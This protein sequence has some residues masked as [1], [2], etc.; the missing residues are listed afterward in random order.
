MTEN[1]KLI[2]QSVNK[3]LGTEYNLISFDSLSEDQLLQVLLDVFLKY[4]IISAKWDVTENDPDETNKTIMESLA[5]IQYSDEDID[6]ASLRRG[7]VR[8]DKKIIYPI[9]E[10]IFENEELITKLAYLA[11]FLMPLNLPPEAMSIPEVMS[12]NS[13]YEIVMDEFKEVHQIYELAVDDGKKTRELRSDSMAIEGEIDNVKKRIERLQA[14]LDKIPQHELLLESAKTLRIEKDK[15]KDLMTQLDEQKQ[16]LYRANVI[17]ERLQKEFQNIKSSTQGTTAKEMLDGIIEEK[18]VLEFMVK[19]KLPQELQ[20]RQSEVQ[21]LEDVINEPTIN[22]EYLQDLQH[23]IDDVNREIQRLVEAKMNDKGQQNDVLGLGPFRQQA[24][25]IAR[26]KDAAAEQLDQLTKELK[27]VEYQLKDKQQKLQETVGEVLLRGDDLKQF[28]NTLRA[29]SNVYKQQRSELAAIKA[30]AS[31]LQETLDNLRAQDPSLS[32]PDE[33]PSSLE[34][35]VSRPDSPLES[36]GITEL[37]RLV[38]G[39]TRAVVAA[40]EKLKP[41]SQ[42]LRPARER[43]AELKDECDSKKQVSG[44]VKKCIPVYI[45]CHSFY[46]FFA[47]KSAIFALQHATR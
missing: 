7:L 46:A 1:L 36:R 47:H 3:L 32:V 23:K 4:G 12:L 26:N 21:I 16:A 39:L 34:P 43:I 24:M 42:Q 25:L 44:E 20:L 30:E 29:K 2:V 22:R 8:G 41:I 45:V 5:K 27:E 19:Q 6:F 31:D 37:S 15:Q 18:Q 14:R 35:M 40:R 13:Q 11:K 10:W 38:D 33:D 9:L 17:N 28:V